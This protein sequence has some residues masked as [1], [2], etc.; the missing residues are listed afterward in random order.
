MQKSYQFN[1][2][3]QSKKKR[4][5]T[6]FSIIWIQLFEYKR[7]KFRLLQVLD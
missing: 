7:R 2:P 1:N 4:H 3:G 5:N 6:K